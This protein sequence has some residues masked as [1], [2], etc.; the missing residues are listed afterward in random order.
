M[1]GVKVECASISSAAST[2]IVINVFG[3]VDDV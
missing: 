2:Y 3:G 1:G